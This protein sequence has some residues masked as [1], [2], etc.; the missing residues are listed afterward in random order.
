MDAW[1]SSLS[2][3]GQQRRRHTHPA[4]VVRPGWADA[5]LWAISGSA[6]CQ[7]L[8]MCHIRVRTMEQHDFLFVN[9][10]YLFSKCRLSA[11]KKVQALF[12]R[13][14][15]ILRNKRN[16]TASVSVATTRPI[17]L[18]VHKR[19]HKKRKHVWEDNSVW[20]GV[21]INSAVF[22]LYLTGEDESIRKSEDFIS[23]LCTRM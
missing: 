20:L 2:A 23:S 14:L 16:N 17:L 3:P 18:P 10:I 21:N 11:N 7:L 6:Q 19:S 1:W 15:G 4:C 5:F 12:R 8:F 13:T 22:V 9:A